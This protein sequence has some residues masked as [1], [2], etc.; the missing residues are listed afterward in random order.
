VEAMRNAYK[1]LG[2]TWLLIG[3]SHVTKES[4]REKLISI[5]ICHNKLKIAYSNV[6]DD[7][8]LLVIS[9]LW[10]YRSSVN[11]YCLITTFRRKDLCSS[12]GVKMENRARTIALN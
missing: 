9:L 8:V 4:S 3:G 6:F 12:S 10:T 2:Q 11:Y 5:L 1:I 7:G